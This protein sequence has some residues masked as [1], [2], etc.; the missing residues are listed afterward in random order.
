MRRLLTSLLVLLV[1]A[2]YVVQAE[3]HAE[4]LTAIPD[5]NAELDRSPVQVELVFSEALEP[6]LSSIGVF[7]SDGHVVDEGDVQVDVNQ[8]ARMTV[9]VHSLAHG[10]YTVSWKAISSV[11]GHLTA[12]SYPFSVGAA[13]PALA[14]PL[15]SSSNPLSAPA[16]AIKWLLLVSIAPLCSATI[17]SKLVWQPALSGAAT[18]LSAAVLRPRRWVRINRLALVGLLAAMGL[19]L[20]VLIGEATG[21]E[22]DWPLAANAA[23]VLTGTRIGFIWLVRLGLALAATWLFVS[24]PAAW[25]N[26]AVAVASLAI[27]GSISLT[28]HAFASRA[29]LV[30]VLIDWLHLAAMCI[31]FGGLIFL[32][33]GLDI[34]KL[35]ESG[36]RTRL[37]S[38]VIGRFSFIAFAAVTILGL[39]GLYSALQTVGDLPDLAANL[40]TSL[41]GEALF[42]KLVTFGL[43]L[44][45]AAVNLLIISPRLSRARQRKTSAQGLSALLMR[46]VTVEIG[47]LGALLAVVSLLTYLPPERS[48]AVQIGGALTV[49]DLRVNLA[50]TPGYVGQNNFTLR[51]TAGGSPVTETKETLL[52]FTARSMDLPPSEIPLREQSDG[53][54]TASG[55]YLSLPGTWQVEAIVRR[56]GRFDAY[57]DF[58]LQVEK[59]KPI[60]PVN[61]PFLLS[62]MAGWVVVV[63]SLLVYFVWFALARPEGLWKGRL[64]KGLGFGLAVL[65]LA[66]GLNYLLWPVQQEISQ[67]NPVPANDLSLLAGEQLYTEHCETCHGLTGKG[68][69]PLGQTLIPPPADLSLHVVAGLYDDAQLYQWISDGVSG[70]RMPSFRS[71]LSVTDRWNLVN[72]L[73]TLAAR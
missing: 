17:F 18:E 50:I 16:V 69:G 36:L 25:K 37:T 68:D 7:D 42:A 8:P 23:A 39:T 72:Y 19:S 70:S 28:S 48:S 52:R 38:L 1:C 63:C 32:L 20:L 73:R 45:I 31:W 61:M 10:V 27:L 46:N 34:F 22:L 55:S 66:G 13:S 40:F 64:A 65:L 60:N 41:Y 43:L 9:S 47:L 35:Y 2:L 44:L 33:S 21:V 29:P 5:A 26:W 51:L 14:Q 54:Y 71:S 3:A 62:R 59:A 12:G 15:E 49:D 56:Q 30:P 53:L 57:A 6:K 11:D 67:V 4:L 24:P 58:Q